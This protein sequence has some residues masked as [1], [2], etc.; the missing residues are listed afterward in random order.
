MPEDASLDA[1]DSENADAESAADEPPTADPAV[2][3]FDWSP[4]GGECADCGE[5]VA[6]RWRADG[7]RGGELVCADCKEW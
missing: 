4:E 6:R 5:S 2:S 1:F 3:T 7:E